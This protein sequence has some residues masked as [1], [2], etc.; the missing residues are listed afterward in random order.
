VVDDDAAV[1]SVLGEVLE[2]DG[3]HV[4]AFGSVRSAR[5][6]LRRHLPALL[7]LDEELPDGR[8]SDLARELRRSGAGR[9]LAVLFC[10]GGGPARRAAL[11][12][13]AP[14]VDKPIDVEH[15]TAVVHEAAAS[16]GSGNG[17][18]R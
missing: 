10:T 17:H 11:G 5:D 7:I 2:S 15:L 18:R 13:L 14:V 16:V 12:R 6:A 9:R 1:R 8:G 4:R 3:W